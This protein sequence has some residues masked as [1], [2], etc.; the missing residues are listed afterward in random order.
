MVAL[1]I[2]RGGFSYPCGYTSYTAATSEHTITASSP[3]K[4][5]HDEAPRAYI[6]AH[7][8]RHMELRNSTF[9]VPPW[10]FSRQSSSLP[11]HKDNELNIHVW[12]LN[13]TII[14]TNQYEDG[15][16]RTNLVVPLQAN[17]APTNQ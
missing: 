10:T 5:N 12:K 1:V 2:L 7:L 14:E 17:D 13:T 3:T 9:V 8:F 15:G 11:Q 6:I 4:N 16:S